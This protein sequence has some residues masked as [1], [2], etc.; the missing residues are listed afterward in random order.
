M[1]LI[2]NARAT[3]MYEK[4]HLRELEAL[5]P[6]FANAARKAPLPPPVKVPPPVRPLT[7]PRSLSTPH[8]APL[9]PQIPQQPPTQTYTPVMS[10]PPAG[11]LA[12]P[13]PGHGQPPH[14]PNPIRPISA[15]APLSPTSPASPA[16]GPSTP[17]PRPRYADAPNY[18]ATSKS[19]FITPTTIAS[20]LTPGGVPTPTAPA[21]PSPFPSTG[22]SDPLLSPGPSYT[23]GGSYAS[24]S[25]TMGRA[26]NGKG[27]HQQHPLAA[28][29]QVPTPTRRLDARE[30]AAKL[31]NFL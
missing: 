8:T 19:M 25:Q 3:I 18:P 20:P 10:R 22:M 27:L 1:A 24:Q 7:P 14:V 13:H 17:T 23:Q 6:E 4:Q 30:A 2:E 29:M 31:A 12:S 16:A 15:Q 28:S 26:T 5:R 21:S 11:P 9:P